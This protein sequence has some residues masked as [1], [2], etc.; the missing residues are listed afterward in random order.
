MVE[1]RWI[2]KN[3]ILIILLVALAIGLVVVAGLLSSGNES[4]SPVSPLS[5]LAMQAVEDDALLLPSDIVE[6]DWYENFI[7]WNTQAS[8][9][10]YPFITGTVSIDW[11]EIEAKPIG[12]HLVLELELRGIEVHTKTVH[13]TITAPMQPGIE[14]FRNIIWTWIDVTPGIYSEY[15]Q[16]YWEL[17]DGTKLQI[18]LWDGGIIEP[19]EDGFTL[20]RQDIEIPFL[21]YFPTI[22]KRGQ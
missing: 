8:L 11:Q 16:A 2:N 12:G 21:Y 18:Q 14:N 7:V 10:S 15:I 4:T 9:I 22:M 13:T 1:K 3:R 5:P 20:Y 17:E 19:E 6:M